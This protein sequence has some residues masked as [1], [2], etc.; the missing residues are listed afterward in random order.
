MKLDKRMQSQIC[1][2]YSISVCW[3]LLIINKQGLFDL[4]FICCFTFLRFLLPKEKNQKLDC[5]RPQHHSDNVSRC[6]W[7]IETCCQML[8][9]VMIIGWVQLLPC[10]IKL[11]EYRTYFL[12]CHI[13]SMTTGIAHKCTSKTCDLNFF[14]WLA[15]RIYITILNSYFLSGKKKLF[16]QITIHLEK[17]PIVQG[18]GLC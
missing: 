4:M 7:Y 14:Y 18:E 2:Q 5:W 17:Q 9:S 12:H 6:L 8:G 11:P 3:D 15:L 16:V 13:S 10:F 1:C